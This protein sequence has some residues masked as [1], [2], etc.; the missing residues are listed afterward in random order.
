[1]LHPPSSS[2]LLLSPGVAVNSFPEKTPELHRDDKAT[3]LRVTLGGEMGWVSG[4][5][6]LDH[7]LRFG[8]KKEEVPSH[9]HPCLVGVSLPFPASQLEEGQAVEMTVIMVGTLVGDHT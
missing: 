1:M 5:Y 3:A 9:P 8:P 2:S 6:S 4:K 7:R